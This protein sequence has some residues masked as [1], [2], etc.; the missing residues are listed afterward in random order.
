MHMFGV[1]AIYSHGCH[2]V[3]DSKG[4]KRIYKTEEEAKAKAAELTDA[5]RN[6]GAGR[7]TEFIPAILY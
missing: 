4:H 3:T 6:N 2:W 5:A 7:S 1:K